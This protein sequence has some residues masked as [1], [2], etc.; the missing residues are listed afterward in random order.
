MMMRHVTT[1][2]EAAA[3]CLRAALSGFWI[4]CFFRGVG[5]SVR[6]LEVGVRGDDAEL[7]APGLHRADESARQDLYAAQVR[8]EELGP[9]EDAHL[10]L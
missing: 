6:Q 1:S 5:V 4:E 7:V 9:E 10:A 2:L 3:R 8:P